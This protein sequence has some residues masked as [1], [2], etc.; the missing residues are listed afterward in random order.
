MT[1]SG[2]FFAFSKVS[3]VVLFLPLLA[4]EKMRMGGF[5]ENTLKKLKGAKLW[6]PFSSIL[7]ANA[8]GLGPIAPS[9]CPCN[10]ET[11]SDFGSNEIIA[12]KGS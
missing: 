6:F 2:T 9:K 5:A 3:L 4:G 8:I 7:L 11:G 12:R 1:H 10:S